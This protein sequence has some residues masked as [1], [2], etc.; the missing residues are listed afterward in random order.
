MPDSSTD[1]VIIQDVVKAFTGHKAVDGLSFTVP[2]GHIFGLLGPNGAGKSTT[3]RMIMDIIRPDSGHVTVLG[4]RLD[5]GVK[6]EV[7]YLPEERGLYRKMKVIEML[8][9]AGSIRNMS[10]AQA[11]VEGQ[12]WLER[13][14]IGD[15]RTKKVEELSKGMQQKVQ[16]IVAVLGK[17]RLLILD[18]PFSGMDPVNQDLFKD[19]ILELNRAGTTIIFSTHQMDTAE[20]LCTEIALIHRGHAV[21][22]GPLGE[23]KRR[24]GSNAIQ[25][26]FEGDGSFLGQIAGVERVSDSARTAEIKLKP[27][28]DPQ[29][30]LRAAVGRLRIRRFE[31][32]EPTLHNI[33]I[34]QVG[35]AGFV[36]ASEA[37]TSEVSR[38]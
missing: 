37:H 4:K 14:G 26:D 19:V 8:E 12:R 17:P 9:F 35:G 22:N 31:I 33:F 7:G 2:E 13:L 28:A 20:R 38:A 25:M 29:E 3:I 1:A 32:M 27:G 11:R 30:V 24:F 36:P 18:E 16:F 21:L 5:Q 6:D 34:E 23:V 15:W 10:I